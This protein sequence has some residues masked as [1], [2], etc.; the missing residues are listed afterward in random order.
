VAVQVAKSFESRNTGARYPSGPFV[1]IAVIFGSLTRVLAAHA[2]EVV[3]IVD[4]RLS[5]AS[6]QACSLCECRR[7][8]LQVAFW[9]PLIPRDRLGHE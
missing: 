7:G 5:T 3:T 4:A 1:R 9:V 6:S 8:F 2:R